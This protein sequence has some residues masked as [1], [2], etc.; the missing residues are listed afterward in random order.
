M[1]I[2][3]VYGLTRRLSC[4][5]Q[6]REP[7]KEAYTWSENQDQVLVQWS[8]GE[9][10]SLHI[11][12]VHAMIILLTY[13]PP[14]QAEPSC[15]GRLLEAWFPSSGELP[16]AFLVETSEEALLYPDWL[17]LRMIRSQVDILVDTALKE[18]EPGQLILFIQS[19]GIPVASMSKLLS[20]L[21]RMVQ[22][23]AFAFVEV[24]MDKSYMQQLFQVQWARGAR[25]GSHFADIMQFPAPCP[26]VSLA[27][28][29]A[30]S[31]SVYDVKPVIHRPPPP[32]QSIIGPLVPAVL[33]VE[34]AALALRQIFD[35][36]TVI[37]LSQP[38]KVKAFRALSQAL[39]SEF[40]STTGRPSTETVAIALDGL[41]DPGSIAMLERQTAFSCGLLRLLTGTSTSGIGAVTSICQKIV[42]QAGPATGTR[43][44][45]TN[46]ARQFLLRAQDASRP[47]G[48]CSQ[49]TPAKESSSRLDL[50]SKWLE[51]HVQQLAGRALATN[52]T[53]SLVDS[54][55]SCLQSTRAH[56]K[57]SVKPDGL[58]V[59]WLELLDPEIVSA[60][61]E[62]EVTTGFFFHI[63]FQLNL[64][65]EAIFA[66]AIPVR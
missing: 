39:C 9:A 27:H 35:I 18:L 49:K 47:D 60:Q 40:N 43:S 15:F 10:A 6:A 53:R 19:F 25:G 65:T 29:A 14:E 36:R 33:T 58:L 37:R 11:L 42:H 44:P 34:A 31:A 61:P 13:G 66:D 64:K 16:Q 32:S 22:A 28:C 56:T 59:D 30:S 5:G 8:T 54:T 7:N 20:A 55:V 63:S 3:F 1:E 12:V 2:L 46:I 21:D 41:L 24:D 52:D 17:K 4:T 48:Q 26:D 38:E 23:N 62:A 51:R 45:L 50:S 57:C